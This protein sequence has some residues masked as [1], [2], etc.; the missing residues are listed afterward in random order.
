MN[1]VISGIQKAPGSNN[2]AI[3][4]IQS[5]LNDPYMC[6]NGTDKQI[7]MRKV[8]FP[9]DDKTCRDVRYSIISPERKLTK[10]SIYID[11]R[12]IK[13]NIDTPIP[14]EKYFCKLDL[15]ENIIKPAGVWVVESNVEIPSHWRPLNDDEKINMRYLL[16]CMLQKEH[17]PEYKDILNKALKT[18]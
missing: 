12:G 9:E 2:S 3:E 7:V 8:C 4:K 16:N 17:K 15:N 5:A 6:K 11:S 10:G 14:Y 13:L 1:K 18:I